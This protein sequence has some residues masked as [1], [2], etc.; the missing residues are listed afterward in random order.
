[1][2]L[3]FREDLK[4]IQSGGTESGEKIRPGGEIARSEPQ[5]NFQL[6]QLGR[7][8]HLQ[9][10]K[11]HF[12]RFFQFAVTIGAENRITILFRNQT[13]VLDHEIH[14]AEGVRVRQSGQI[15]ADRKFGFEM[16]HGPVPV[17]F[18]L[19]ELA[20][21]GRPKVHKPVFHCRGQIDGKGQDAARFLFPVV[22]GQQIG[23]PFPFGDIHFVHLRADNDVFMENTLRGLLA[24][25]VEIRAF[26]RL[27]IS[28]DHGR[29]IAE[30][31]IG[32]RLH[33]EYHIPDIG[34]QSQFKRVNIG[35][36]LIV[37]TFR[38]IIGIPEIG[39]IIFQFSQFGHA[40]PAIKILSVLASPDGQFLRERK[41]FQSASVEPDHAFSDRFDC[42][43][44]DHN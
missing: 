3:T 16:Q 2:V 5:G 8:G 44:I 12:D 41:G 30:E 34:I 42:P 4:N 43:E 33:L 32:A 10:F 20:D 36:S 6:F 9:N 17:L 39:K 23:E 40:L 24:D 13:G 22:Q 27:R 37:F 35:G 31:V 14:G 38:Q 25:P 19:H 26:H 1:M 15:G 29:F 11:R 7:L 18:T 21:M 28:L